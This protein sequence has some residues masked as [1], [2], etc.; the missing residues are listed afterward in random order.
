MLSGFAVFPDVLVVHEGATGW[1]FDIEGRRVFVS[2]A[3]IQP[4]TTV[5]LAGQRGP[6]SIAIEALPD[7]YEA[8]RRSATAIPGFAAPR[9]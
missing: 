5:P 1:A 9:R 8:F 6:V 7:V 4:A 3:Q 2:S